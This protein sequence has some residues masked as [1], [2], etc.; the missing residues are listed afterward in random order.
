MPLNDRTGMQKQNPKPLRN[1]MD[2]PAHVCTYSPT[3]TKAD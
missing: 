2:A 3:A 1:L